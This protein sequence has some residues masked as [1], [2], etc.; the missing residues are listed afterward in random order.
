MIKIMHR[1]TLSYQRIPKQ[2]GICDI[3]IDGSDLSSGII[4]YKTKHGNINILKKANNYKYAYFTSLEHNASFGDNSGQYF[5]GNICHTSIEK[6]ILNKR[7]VYWF[8]NLDALIQHK[9][10]MLF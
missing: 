3:D 1:Y 6:A 5:K 9:N 2:D 7:Y 8:K 4:C 10:K